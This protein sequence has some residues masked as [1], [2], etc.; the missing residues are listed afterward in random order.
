MEN[1]SNT[2]DRELLLTRTL[3]A[4]VKL[5]WEVWTKPEHLA[6]WWGPNGFTNTISDMEVKPGGAF[7]LI[8]HG[9]D[10]TDYDNMSTYN[11]VVPFEKLVFEHTTYP[12]ILFT[13]SFEAQGDKTLLRWHMLFDSAE[14]LAD[15]AKKHQAIEGQ[16]QNVEKLIH[17][18][19]DRKAERNM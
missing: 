17:Y 1:R 16:K 3:N 5:V 14:I 2:N 15:V 8:M 7:N 6:N 18:L 11:E 10:G 19:E 4:P 12:H 13:I 9:P